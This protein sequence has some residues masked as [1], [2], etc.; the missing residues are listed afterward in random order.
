MAS[1]LQLQVLAKLPAFGTLLLRRIE[2]NNG[3][4][5]VAFSGD[6]SYVATASDDTTVRVWKYDTGKEVAKFNQNWEVNA[7]AFSVDD[8]YLAIGSRNKDVALWEY[9]TNQKLVQFSHDSAVFDVSFSVDGKYLATASNDNTVRVWELKTGKEVVRLNHDSRVNAVAFSGDGENLATGSSDETARVWETSTGKE[10]VKLNYDSRVNAVAFSPDGKYLATGSDDK[11]AQIHFY[12]SDDLINEACRRLHRNLTAEE[13]ERYMNLDL[14]Q[15]HKTCNSLPVH[16]SVV[17][18]GRELAK[19][20]K[21]QEAT[22]I[23]R[24]VLELEPEL[25]LDP[26]TKEND[27]EAVARKL[28]DAEK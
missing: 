6:G 24:R 9:K 28:A 14:D 18:K 15:Y 13:W 27:P 17:A 12:R 21:I 8:K 23:F 20:G 3:I 25:D 22:S 19:E 16:P 5:A 7:I 11:T 10:T 1:I 2:H 26:D 4:N